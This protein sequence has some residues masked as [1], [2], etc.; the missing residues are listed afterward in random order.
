M[1]PEN[2]SVFQLLKEVAFRR[3]MVFYNTRK[4][5]YFGGIRVRPGVLWLAGGIGPK[6]SVVSCG[7][8]IAS[9]L[10][11]LY[12]SNYSHSVARLNS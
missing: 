1:S 10:S 12:L 3:I 9:Q 6:V 8:T 5:W 4:W 11:L 7:T 2:Q